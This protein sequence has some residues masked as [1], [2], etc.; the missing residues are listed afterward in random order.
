MPREPHVAFPTT[1]KVLQSISPA[2]QAGI[3]CQDIPFYWKE[4]FTSILHLCG[5]PPF[6]SLSG[7]GSQMHCQTQKLLTFVPYLQDIKSSGV[8]H[9]KGSCRLPQHPHAGPNQGAFKQSRGILTFEPV[10]LPELYWGLILSTLDV[11]RS[12]GQLQKVRNQTFSG[13]VLS[14]GHLMSASD[15]FPLQVIQVPHNRDTL[16]LNNPRTSANTLINTLEAMDQ[17]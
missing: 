13:P 10:P 11:P 2:W 12:Q 15:V 9:I 4:G 16:V 1:D 8:K 6:Q 14:A 5:H 17:A 3:R 7:I